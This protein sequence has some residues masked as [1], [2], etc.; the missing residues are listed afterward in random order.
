M[1]DDISRGNRHSRADEDGLRTRDDGLSVVYSGYATSGHQRRPGHFKLDERSAA[2]QLLLAGHSLRNT[3]AIVGLSNVT[4]LRLKK[5]MRLDLSSVL[6][7]CGRQA[8]HKGWCSVRYAA[9]GR[10]QEFMKSWHERQLARRRRRHVEAPRV[11][12]SEK[13]YEAALRLYD[14]WRSRA[15]LIPFDQ[16][17]RDLAFFDSRG[18][19]CSTLGKLTTP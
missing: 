10:R 1:A 6:C 12:N 7:G 18:T 9:S 17:L 2:A 19:L 11:V 13:D 14:F 5:E 16:W 3:A 4:V 8:T 15:V